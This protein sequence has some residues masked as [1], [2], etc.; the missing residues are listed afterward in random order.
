MF[1]LPSLRFVHQVHFSSGLQH[2]QN[3]SYK[4]NYMTNMFVNLCSMG[5]RAESLGLTPKSRF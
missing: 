2:P 4:D 1:L 3:Y 5:R